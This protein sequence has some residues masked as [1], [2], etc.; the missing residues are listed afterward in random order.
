MDLPI[1]TAPTNVAPSNVANQDDDWC[2]SSTDDSFDDS[3]D[4]SSDDLEYDD[5]TDGVASDSESDATDSSD[6]ETSDVSSTDGSD[7]GD[8]S[9]DDGSDD[10]ISYDYSI[11]TMDDVE[12]YSASIV[13]LDGSVRSVV[14]DNFVFNLDDYLTQRYGDSDGMFHLNDLVEFYVVDASTL[15][16]MNQDANAPADDWLAAADELGL[17]G[18]DNPYDFLVVRNDSGIQVVDIPQSISTSTYGGSTNN[19]SM[20]TDSLPSG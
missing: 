10:S 20:I 4:N 2:T 17:T 8:L 15:E 19:G 7:S 3:L 12:L 13:V 1:S 14:N 9:S 5:A 11:L 18:Y 6:S 16:A